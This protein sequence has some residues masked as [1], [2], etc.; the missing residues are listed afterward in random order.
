MTN[1][2]RL[3]IRQNKWKDSLAEWAKARKVRESERTVVRVQSG[4]EFAR[5]VG[6]VGVWNLR[7]V[8]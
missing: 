5:I 7:R 2:K 4:A 3:K 1:D 8:E 6:S